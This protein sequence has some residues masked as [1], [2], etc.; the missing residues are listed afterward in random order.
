[1]DCRKRC[2]LSP[3]QVYHTKRPPLFAARLR[4]AERRVGS[5][6]TADIC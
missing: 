5:S 4:A 6:A 1:M 2:Q 3:S